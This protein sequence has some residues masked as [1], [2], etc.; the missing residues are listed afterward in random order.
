MLFLGLGTGLGS[1]LIVDDVIGPMELAH[2][3]Y[4]RGRTYEDYLGDHGRR[5]LGAKKCAV[6]FGRPPRARLKGAGSL[7]K[8]SHIDTARADYSA[9]VAT[10]ELQLA[11]T[12]S[13]T[14]LGVVLDEQLRWREQVQYSS[15][16]TLPRI[17]SS[18]LFGH[19]AHQV[20]WPQRVYVGRSCCRRS[21]TALR[22]GGA[23]SSAASSAG[24][25]GSRCPG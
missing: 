9:R 10:L 8:A 21:R 7:E 4:K 6:V 18:G 22:Y 12:Q 16:Q 25:G 20:P 2:L 5:R 15:A 3:P 13:Y 14:F 11:R 1:A 24:T 19:L 23:L 17:I